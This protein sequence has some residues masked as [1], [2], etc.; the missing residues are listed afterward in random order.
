MLM[1]SSGYLHQPLHYFLPTLSI[2]FLVIP[3][4]ASVSTIFFSKQQLEGQFVPFSI[5]TSALPTAD[6]PR[7]ALHPCYSSY[8]SLVINIQ[9]LPKSSSDPFHLGQTG[10][11][12]GL[13]ATYKRGSLGRPHIQRRKKSAQKEQRRSKCE[14]KEDRSHEACQQALCSGHQIHLTPGSMLS[15]PL[16]FHYN[17][18]P[19]V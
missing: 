19:L 14:V 4:Q 5:L 12:G 17:S 15:L 9:I 18:P 3:T 8:S 10:D 6:A 11:Q 7:E 2:S 13:V 16:G 1:L